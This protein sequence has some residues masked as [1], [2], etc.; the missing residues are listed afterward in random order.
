MTLVRLQ[1]LQEL[2]DI[3]AFLQLG[4]LIDDACSGGYFI[5]KGTEKVILIQE[6]L[7]K[8]RIIVEINGKDQLCASVTRHI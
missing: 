8:N 3:G 4:I 6:Q 2:F 7:S 5:I 1:S